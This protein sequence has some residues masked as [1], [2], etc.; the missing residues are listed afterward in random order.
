MG[1]ILRGRKILAIRNARALAGLIQLHPADTILTSFLCNYIIQISISSN[2]AS[3][4]NWS[5][6]IEL[7]AERACDSTE[8]PLSLSR[9]VD[10]HSRFAEKCGI[11]GAAALTALLYGMVIAGRVAVHQFDASFFVTAGYAFCEPSMVPAGLRVEW[12]TGYDGQFYYRIALD[13]GR[14]NALFMESRSITLP[15][16]SS[17][18]SIR[19][20]LALRRWLD[21]SGCHGR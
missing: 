4:N 13:P 12:E 7:R 9:A 20:W 17:G 8:T 6:G 2:D 18:S 1:A 14:P 5:R 21:R 15:G 19:Y 11:I 3:I 10:L 16:A